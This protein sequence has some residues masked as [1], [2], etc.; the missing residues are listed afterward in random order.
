MV[1]FTDPKTLFRIFLLT[2]PNGSWDVLAE[3]TIGRVTP[4]YILNFAI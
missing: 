2:V 3:V 1:R 4:L